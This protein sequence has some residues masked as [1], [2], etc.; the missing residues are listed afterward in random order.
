MNT[1]AISV[2][3]LACLGTFLIGVLLWL[4]LRLPD[5]RQMG[6][7]A[8]VAG[9]PGAAGGGWAGYFAG[10]ALGDWLAPAA[11]IVH[12]LCVGFGILAG[13]AIG[14]VVVFLTMSLFLGG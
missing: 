8:V 10:D 2:I 14:V 4:F 13:A 11:P 12:A 5:E 6:C 3:G 1:D 9:I 7:V